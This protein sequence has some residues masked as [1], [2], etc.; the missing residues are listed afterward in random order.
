MH[1]TGQARTH[2]PQPMQSSY[3]MKSFMRERLGST[4]F[5]SGYCRQKLGVNRCRQ[6]TRMPTNIVCSPCQM[7]ESQRFMRRTPARAGAA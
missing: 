7:S 6:V 1:C 4:H 2:W 5:S 3:F